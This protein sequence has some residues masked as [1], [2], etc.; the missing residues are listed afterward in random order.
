MDNLEEDDFLV[1]R[2]ASPVPKNKF[3][4]LRKGKA[5]PPRRQKPISSLLASERDV[6]EDSPTWAQAFRTKE[7]LASLESTDEPLE[8]AR[9]LQKNSFLQAEEILDACAE[10]PSEMPFDASPIRVTSLQTTLLDACTRTGSEDSAGTQAEGAALKACHSVEGDH[11]SDRLIRQSL[12]VSEASHSNK[13]NQDYDVQSPVSIASKETVEEASKITKKFSS[14]ADEARHSPEGT[15]LK[16]QEETAMHLVANNNKKIEKNRLKKRGSKSFKSTKLREKQ[17][18][19]THSGMREAGSKT[20]RNQ[21]QVTHGGE[22]DELDDNDE[23]ALISFLHREAKTIK[24]NCESSMKITTVKPKEAGSNTREASIVKKPK[25]ELVEEIHA[26]SQRLLRET[27]GVAFTPEPIAQKS[28]M[29]VLERIR[30]RKLQHSQLALNTSASLLDAPRI[31]SVGHHQYEDNIQIIE[32]VEVATNANSTEVVAFGDIYESTLHYEHKNSHNHNH[33]GNTFRPPIE[34]TQDLF[35]S[36]EIGPDDYLEESSFNA[37]NSL[38]LGINL[39]LDT[40]TQDEELDRLYDEEFNIEK[41]TVLSE[42]PVQH[43]NSAKASLLKELLD[44]EAEE[45]EDFRCESGDEDEDADDKIDDLIAPPE[46]EAATE[47]SRRSRLHRKWLEQKD[48]AMTDDILFRLKTGWKP[49]V[50]DQ[51]SSFL[52]EDFNCSN[53]DNTDIHRGGSA[54]EPNIDS[55]V[56]GTKQTNLMDSKDDSSM[57]KDDVSNLPDV[58]EQSE[59][60]E[61]EKVEEKLFQQRLLKESE[62]QEAFLSPAEDD[63]SREV[64]GFINKVNV[65]PTKTKPSA[66][67]SDIQVFVTNSSSSGNTKSSFLGRMLSS[68]LPSSHRQGFGNSRSFIFGRDDSNSSHG[69]PDNE[70]LEA[71]LSK[72]TPSDEGWKENRKKHREPILTNLTQISKIGSTG[73]SL[74][75][76]LKRQATELDRGLQERNTNVIAEKGHLFRNISM[77]SRSFRQSK[78]NKNSE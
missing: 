30:L 39:H 69:F 32:H 52:D 68:S 26:E 35:C 3:K 71:T 24:A 48:E 18:T 49:R 14:K 41:F 55:V 50:R 74:F 34:D 57:E 19:V 65:P 38:K 66:G 36:S 53:G 72:D 1:Q 56:L 64:L 7:R 22:T 77:F 8:E 45:D 76:I 40:E 75:E 16:Q 54:A 61:D 21:R 37:N 17:E 13:I 6:E 20:I 70:N 31:S 47:C 28:L 67:L 5:S 60:S 44:D 11:G 15:M 23:E 27:R 9:R 33:G 4:R 51:K 58:V 42:Q 46:E 63:T 10:D 29:N 2:G 59:S 25:K 62:D 12:A 43:V 73:P 78:I